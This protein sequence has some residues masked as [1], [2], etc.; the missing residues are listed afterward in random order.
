MKK[1]I[2]PGPESPVGIFDSGIG[3]LTVADAI[4]RLLPAE[5]LIYF[6]DTA[7]LP[8]GDKAPES[9][10]GYSVKI[11]DFLLSQGCKM[12]VIACNTASSIAYETVKKHVGSKALVVDV[13]NPVVE[14]VVG[15]KKVKHVG[16]IGTR[17]TIKSEA[18]AN[19]ITAFN[20]SMKVSSLATPLLAPMI[21]E[22][23]FNN[24][25]SRTIINS[26][27]SRPKIK[28][29]DA[30]ILAC[31]H[32]PLIKPEIAEYY[33][34]EI[35]I[36]DSATIVAHSVKKLLDENDLNNSIKV[37]TANRHRFYISDFTTSFEKSTKIFFKG[38][39]RLEHKNLW[40][41]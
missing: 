35:T 39:I 19:R 13:I 34:K 5:T 4:N 40:K 26:Y 32:Y 1:N 14:E 10:R 17:A 30:L 11:A 28:K 36:V 23:F 41:P 27:L 8:Y 7:H 21:E 3:G 18:Y 15:M 33:K 38:K 6:G 24:K 31:T 12:I 20:P 25:I 9:I 22:G 16:V 29:V 37:K 2:K